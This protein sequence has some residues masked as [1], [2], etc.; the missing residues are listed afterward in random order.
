M[1]RNFFLVFVIL[2]SFSYVLH[3]SSIPTT[4]TKN[5]N[6]VDTSVFPSLPQ[7]N[8]FMELE[9]GEKMKEERLMGRRVDLELH[10]YEGPG[11]NKEHDPKSP[12]GN[13]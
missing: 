2:L 4:R 12:G 11:A 5:L 6:F 8:G 9:N 1:E 7:E 13:G 3:V 10:D